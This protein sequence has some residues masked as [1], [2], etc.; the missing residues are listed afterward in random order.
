MSRG[1]AMRS[2]HRLLRGTVAGAAIVAAAWG[3]PWAQ[4][5]SGEIDYTC[6]YSVGETVGTGVA[7]ATFDSGVKDGLVVPVGQ[8]V[9]LDPMTGSITL[10]EGFTDAL[11]STGLTSIRGSATIF[12]GIKET[13]DKLDEARLAFDAAVPAEGPFTVQVSGEIGE[14]QPQKAGTYTLMTG[15]DLFFYTDP[16]GP[17]GDSGVTCG[18]EGGPGTAIDTFTAT[19]AATATTTVTATASPERPTVVQTDFAGEPPTMP[20]PL[21][22]GVGLLGLTGAAVGA[23]AAAGRSRSRPY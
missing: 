15:S 13:G 7:T 3:P 19:G 1:G 5:A 22:V 20:V 11:R 2:N 12:L 8:R 6:D 14:Y 17:F 16:E 10:P 21:V 18:P 9:S 4:A 23:A